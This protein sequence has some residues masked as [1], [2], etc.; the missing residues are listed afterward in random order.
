MTVRKRFHALADDDRRRGG[1]AIV[2]GYRR[3]PH[4]AND[5]TWADEATIQMIAEEPW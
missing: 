2:E 4:T 1:Q 3:I 5:G